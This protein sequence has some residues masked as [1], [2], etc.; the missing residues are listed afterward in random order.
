MQKYL[1]CVNLIMVLV[2]IS[3]SVLYSA[4]ILKSFENIIKFIADFLLC[5]ELKQK[6]QIKKENEK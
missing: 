2:C 3:F 1:L 4:L 6:K 5:F